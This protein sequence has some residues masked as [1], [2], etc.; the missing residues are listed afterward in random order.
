MVN[1]TF[2]WA[3]YWRNKR[4]IVLSPLWQRFWMRPV[5]RSSM[6]VDGHSKSPTP[7]LIQLSWFFNWGQSHQLLELSS[8]VLFLI[9]EWEWF[10]TAWEKFSVEFLPLVFLFCA[11][12]RH[13]HSNYGT[14]CPMLCAWL[15]QQQAGRDPRISTD[16]VSFWRNVA[17]ETLQIIIF[18]RH[19]QKNVEEKNKR[20]G[21]WK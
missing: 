10:L 5:G 15:L 13:L 18:V 19:W 3:S 17:R 14:T 6:S 4:M 8:L 1:R 2:N 9:W 16:A 11:Q 12:Q 21:R 20:P 7:F